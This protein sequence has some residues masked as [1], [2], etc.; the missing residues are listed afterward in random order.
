MVR[1]LGSSS[2]SSASRLAAVVVGVEV[3]LDADGNI[4]KNSDVV[5]VV[6]G[7]VDVGLASEFPSS[8]IGSKGRGVV[9]GD[10]V[11]LLKVPMRGLYCVLLAETC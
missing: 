8:K 10:G 4:D 7:N 6:A 11:D 3:D 9:G 2:S 5:A 1:H